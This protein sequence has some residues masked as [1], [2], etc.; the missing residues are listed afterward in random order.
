MELRQLRYFV[1]LAE[2]L[3][4]G[5]AAAR[6][7]IV[8]SALSQQIQ[9]LER[10]LDVSLFERNTHHVRISTAGEV[11]L[12]EIRRLLSQLEIAVTAARTAT[13]SRAVVKVAIGDASLDS[14]PQI[15]RLVHYRYPHLEIHQIEAGVPEQQRMLADGRLDVGFGRASSAAGDIATEVVRLEPVG[16]MVGATHPLGRRASVPVALL[17][18]EPLLL[19]D[20]ARAPEFNQFVRE[21]CCTAG[22]TPTIY[23]GSVQS[24]CAAA[25]LVMHESVVL[26]VPSSCGSAW[27][28]TRW[29]PLAVPAP[30]YPWSLLWRADAPT[31]Q[32]RAVLECAR[33]VS[34]RLRWTEL[35]TDY[36]EQPHQVE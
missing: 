36:G 30:C 7:H 6:E 33:E 26:C 3:H 35:K 9:R 15:L 14:M 22:F 2:E 29:V 17:A 24:V 16:V 19:A 34:R 12:V 10:E 23:R 25:Q 27:P 11:F 31:D 5:R 32:V 13:T 4:F 20:E 8:Q 1:T 28:G 21:M 18:G